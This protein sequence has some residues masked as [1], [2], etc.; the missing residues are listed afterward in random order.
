MT[1]LVIARQLAEAIARRSDNH[2]SA[3]ALYPWPTEKTRAMDEQIYCVYITANE[4]RTVLYT[5]VTG[6]LKKRVWQ[7]KAKLAAGFT[8]RYN[9]SRLVYFETCPNP[10]GAIAREKQI[11]GSSRAK[12]IALIES[13]NPHWRDL[14]DG[15]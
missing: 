14:Y 9:A 13:T 11:K 15:L 2:D 6:D 3:F 10:I 8:N 12:K 1:D 7:H 5:G 4:R